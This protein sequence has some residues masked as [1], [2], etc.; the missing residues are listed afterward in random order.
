MS[1]KAGSTSRDE[2]CRVVATT[3]FDTDSGNEVTAVGWAT[4][5]DNECVNDSGCA[6]A[7]DL[8]ASL[9]AAGG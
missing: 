6:S 4:V 8:G 2:G 1:S 5:G 7:I 3:S 9:E